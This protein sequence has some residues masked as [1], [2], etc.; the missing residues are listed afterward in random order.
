MDFKPILDKISLIRLNQEA[1]ARSSGAR[2]NVFEVLG[3]SSDETRLH[4]A[5]I[6][7]LLDPAGSH[8]QGDLYLRLFIEELCKDHFP[9]FAT[10]NALVETEHHI[11]GTTTGRIDILVREAKTRNPR[12]ILIENKIYAGDQEFQLGRYHN[13][14]TDQFGA[15]NFV[16]FYL[17]L[18]GQEP[19]DFSRKSK[20]KEV[21]L[22]KDFFLI[23]YRDEIHNWLNRCHKESSSLPQIRETIAQY[24]M[25]V[26]KLS[27]KSNP[28]DMTVKLESLISVDKNSLESLIALRSSFKEFLVETQE[29]FWNCLFDE[30]SRSY[31]QVSF[32]QQHSL[33]TSLDR[34]MIR[35]YYEGARNNKYYGIIIDLHD[36]DKYSLK[37]KLELGGQLYYGIMA[38]EAGQFKWEKLLKGSK[39]PDNISH[40]R[41]FLIE[42]HHWDSKDLNWGWLAWKW[43]GKDISFCEDKDDMDFIADFHKNGIESA[44]FKSLLDEVKLAVEVIQAAHQP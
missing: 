17:T 28:F 43:P 36:L 44:Y 7:E 23:S 14:G 6:A 25:L 22:N 27:G 39:L 21:I 11:A 19:S 10:G 31:D 26:S 3:V 40:L 30:L 18:E 20:S 2:F 5:F 12:A 29:K 24:L 33:V 9:D 34:N 15:G 35:N 13:Y 38:Y 4:S 42:E 32:Y 16:L 41:S 37:L 1:L 8:S